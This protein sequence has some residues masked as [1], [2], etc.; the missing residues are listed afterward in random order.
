MS[1][2]YLGDLTANV[3]PLILPTQEAGYRELWAGETIPEGAEFWHYRAETWY[4]CTKHS[5]GTK[6]PESKIHNSLVYVA[7][8]VKM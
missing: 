1:L 4:P 6:V 8:R 7:V 5:I 3:L 2:E